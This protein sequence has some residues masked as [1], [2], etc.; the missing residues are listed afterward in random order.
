MAE[1]LLRV[2]NLKTY[3]YTLRGVVKAVDNVSF[4]LRK[5]EVLGLAGESGCGKSTTAYSIINLVPPPGRIV[6]GHIYLDGMDIAR[7]SE[8]EL[9]RKVR[10]KRISMVFQGAM[11][12]LTPVYT[13]G[14]QIAEPLIYHAGMEKQEAMERVEELLS[15]VGLDPGIAKR[16]PHELSGGQKQRVV[17]AMALALN[18]DLVIADEPTTALD[19]VVQA[20]ILN[21]LKELQ[22]KL[23]MS[24][25][26]ITHDLSIIAELAD[27]VAVMYAGKIVEWG[28]ADV[29]FTEPKH[30]YT[31]ALLRAIPRLRGPID[32]LIW[33]PGTPPDL[34]A[35]PPG[36]RF[37]PRCT[38]VMDICR[39]EEPPMVEVGKEHY[40]A[41]WLY[42][43]R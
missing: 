21:L 18:P 42:A 5:G 40:V 34:I 31:Q 8:H 25:I 37:Y 41:C 29:I 7:M 35:P 38:K 39:R 28:P 32:K 22:R 14:Y 19:V 3:F 43:K 23:K 24:I 15:L 2:E 20:Q 4:T 36:C 27:K 30:P 12:A 26:L 11:N 1:E 6:G 9:R 13:V 10:W 17:I 16:Y 33:I